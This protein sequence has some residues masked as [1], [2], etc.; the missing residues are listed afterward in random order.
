MPLNTNSIA[1]RQLS[2]ETKDRIL[3]L[4]KELGQNNISTSQNDN[5]STIKKAFVDKNLYICST[6]SG[7]VQWV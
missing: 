2:D 4:I 5:L 7:P 1:L 6:C 3:T